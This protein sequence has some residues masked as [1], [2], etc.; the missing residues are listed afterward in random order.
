MDT[1]SIREA[2]DSDAPSIREI[3]MLTYQG[4]YAHPEFFDV[5]YIKKLIYDDDAVA[6]V[7][8]DGSRIL[9]AASVIMDIGAF[10]DLIGEFGRLV[11]HPQARSRGIGARLMEGRLER[12]ADRLHT[13]LVENR[14]VHP[15]SQKISARHG[16]H[17]VGFLPS[18]RKCSFRENVALYAKHFG[19]CLQLRKNHPQIIPE[20]YLLACEAMRPLGLSQDI[21]V[22]EGAP[23][24]VSD[25]VFELEE[26]TSEGYNSLLRLERGRVRR[27]EIFGPVKLHAG[28]FQLRV[29]RCNYLIA[30]AN[31]HLVGGIGYHIDP[32]EEAA[33]IVELVTID[34]SPIRFL[35]ENA[36]DELQKDEQVKYVE[37]D[38]NAHSPS[39]QRTFLELGFSPAAYIPA[40]AFHRV[41]RIDVIRMAKL[42]TH[43][44]VDFSM[45]HDTTRPIAELVVHSFE[46]AAAP[47][48]IF[49]VVNS[50]PF[51]EGT[52]NEQ[53][54]VIAGICRIETFETGQAMASEG[55]TDGRA[56]LVVQGKVSISLGDKNATVGS[57]SPNQFA[58]EISLLHGTPHQASLLAQE[59]TRALVFERD[60]VEPLLRKR[61]DIGVVLHKNLADQLA[62]KLL[63]VDREWI[64]FRES[65]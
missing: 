8:E 34:D 55:A 41:E 35:L 62:Q 3:F 9:G 59:P 53:R 19:H 40:M 1:L 37:V 5:S 65:S 44:E 60:L 46:R 15:Y 36:L 29:K 31:G 4:E 6:L 45:L 54:S 14:A 49:E 58:G 48:E 43:I 32:I 11:V 47:N 63:K 18:K 13:A 26:M 16:F 12:V 21:T 28:L 25:R 22:D 51:F 2:R 39:M 57:V 38:I 24:Y 52:T 17:S 7:A 27:R 30:R 42:Y 50:N 10:G 64:A 20:A 61:P 33:R 23:A 56:F